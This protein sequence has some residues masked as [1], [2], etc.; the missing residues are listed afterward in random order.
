[1]AGFEPTASSSRTPSELGSG[2]GG[3][4]TV[5]VKALGCLGISCV[6]WVLRT[7]SSP[8]I[9]PRAAG[10][11]EQEQRY[12]GCGYGPYVRADVEDGLRR[13]N[14]AAGIAI[15]DLGFG[16]PVVV[17]PLAF[18]GNGAADAGAGWRTDR[19]QVDLVPDWVP[20]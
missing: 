3:S 6:A 14:A 1:V 7:R 2:P 8:E 19:R 15:D 16:P 17:D 13:E 11:S 10:L 4:T 20:A 18:D 12:Q 5:Q 9:L